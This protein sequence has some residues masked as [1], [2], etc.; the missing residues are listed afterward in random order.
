F[1]DDWSVSCATKPADACF[2]DLLFRYETKL[3][4]SSTCARGSRRPMQDSL[5]LCSA[6]S[7]GPLESSERQL[8]R[9][10]SRRQGRDS[11]RWLHRQTFQSRPCRL[12][13]PSPSFQ[14][15]WLAPLRWRTSR[16]KHPARFCC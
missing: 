14:R 9:H 11:Q 15:F 4:N 10:E 3:L 8:S 12:P 2:L 7:P 13:A 16:Q 5:F 1:E 6:S